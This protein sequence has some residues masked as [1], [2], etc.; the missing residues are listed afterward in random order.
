MV[1][2]F[3]K[4]PD[5]T[6]KNA[7]VG[8]ALGMD[9]LFFLTAI[10]VSFV[11]GQSALATKLWET[12]VAMNLVLVGFLNADGKGNPPTPPPPAPAGQ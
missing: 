5:F 11:P 6:S 8:I 7:A 10:G 9:V 4:R 1:F 3:P 2:F 12:F